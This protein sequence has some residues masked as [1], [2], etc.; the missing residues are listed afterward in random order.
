MVSE[1][2]LIQFN[3]LYKKAYGVKLTRK[4]LIEKANRLLNLYKAVYGTDKNIKI[5]IKSEKKIQ[6]KKIK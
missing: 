3:K 2:G 1:E 6:P 4:D 5:N